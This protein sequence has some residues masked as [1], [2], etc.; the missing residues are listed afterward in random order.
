MRIARRVVTAMVAIAIGSSASFIGSAAYAATPGGSSDTTIRGVRVHIALPEQWLNSGGSWTFGNAHLLLRG[1][2]NLVILK[3]NTSTV[4]W[5]SNT[6]GQG[7]KK[8]LF[9]YNGDLQLLTSSGRVI[10]HTGTDSPFECDQSP[11][12]SQALGLQN[13]SNF[14]IY[15]GLENPQGNGLENYDPIWATNTNGI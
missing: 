15:C 2:G 3:K 7:V 1:D 9:K 8:M 10:W 4:K 11:G 14:V 6:A 5:Q 12:E 13:D